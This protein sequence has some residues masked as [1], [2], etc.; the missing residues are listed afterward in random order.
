MKVKTNE[1]PN[2]KLLKKRLA[3]IERAKQDKFNEEN[4]LRIGGLKNVAAIWKTNRHEQSDC[5]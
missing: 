4:Y 2:M 3:K 5:F 1:Q